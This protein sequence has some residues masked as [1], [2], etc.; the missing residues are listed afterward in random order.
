MKG[1]ILRSIFL[2]IFFGNSNFSLAMDKFDNEF[3]EENP[4]RKKKKTM[5]QMNLFDFTPN[6]K[7]PLKSKEEEENIKNFLSD[8]LFPI[9]SGI[10]YKEGIPHLIID[11]IVKGSTKRS[12]IVV[13]DQHF[14]VE[15][16]TQKY[17]VG[18]YDI[19]SFRTQ[20]CPKQSK[21]SSSYERCFPC[22]QLL[23]FNPSFYNV[24]ADQLSEKQKKYNLEPHTVYLAYFGKEHVK[25]GI[26]NS[27]RTQTRLLEQG[28]RAAL[29]IKKCEDAYKAREIESQV[30]SKTDITEQ[31]RSDQK[32][33]LIK[34]FN[35]EDAAKTLM[36]TRKLIQSKLDLELNEDEPINFQKF[37]LGKNSIGGAIEDLSSNKTPKLTGKGIGMIG[38]V[39]LLDQGNKTNI[40]SLKKFIGFRLLKIIK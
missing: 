15:F 14:S 39:L 17:C 11:D 13:Q 25:I 23:Q 26:A 3:R 36:E 37:Y 5:T 20:S 4:E 6:S 2:V 10:E 19:E 31:M 21:I 30:S 24:S 40:I 28:A 34:T 1:N 33:K 27:R 7:T 22:S 9:L 18:S 12:S 8:F 35:F 32:R 16:D 29:L 38:D